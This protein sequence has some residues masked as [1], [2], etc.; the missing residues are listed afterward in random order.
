MVQRYYFFQNKSQMCGFLHMVFHKFVAKK[1]FFMRKRCFLFSLV[2]FITGVMG[3]AHAA[4]PSGGQTRQ[5]QLTDLVDP[6]IGTGGHG[7]VFL[8]AN[9]PFGLVQLGP[10]Q[11]VRGWDWCSGYHYSDSVLVGFSHMHLSGTGIGDLGDV[12][13]LPAANPSVRQT[14]HSHQQERVRPGYYS[15][16]MEREGIMA[17]LTATKRCGMHRYTYPEGSD[18]YLLINLDKGIGWDATTDC[19]LR[20]TDATTI[21]GCRR[22][23]GWA[24]DQWIFFAAEFS[25]PV[26]VTPLN[27]DSLTLVQAAAGVPLVVRVGLSPVSTDNALLNLREEIQTWDFD[28]VTAS[29][30][31]AWE[32]Q[33][34]KIRVT[35]SDQRA[36]RIFYT[37]LYHTMVA[38]SVYS[39]VNGDYRGADG[40]VRRDAFCNYTTF[41][42]W[43]TYRAAHPLMT[44]IHPEMQR[45]VAQTML[46]IYQQQG[47]LPV[48]H[49]MGN[50]T[51]CMVGNPAIPVVADLAIK[52]F[53]IDVTLAFEAARASAMREERGM[54][55]LQ[56]Y[57]FIPWDL[58]PEYETV[59]KGLE[60]ALAD[61]GVARLAK[62][63]GKTADEVAFRQR[64]R[65]YRHYFDPTTRFFR[66][67]DSLGHFRTP[68]SPFHA[69]HRKDD[70]T[71]GNAWQ[72]LWLVPHDVEGLVGLL[73]GPHKFAQKLDSLFVVEGDMGAE[74]SPDISGLIGQYA[75][76][77]EPSHHVIYLYNYV[78]MPWKA[79]PLLRRVLSELY[80]D[81]PDGLCGN[82]DVGQMSAWYV[83]SAMGLYQVE[84]AGGRYVIGSPLFDTM[85][86]NVGGGKT[87]KVVA[88]DN[89]KTNIYVQSARLNGRK[90]TRSY[91]DFK[92]IAAGG[93]LELV[94]GPRPSRFG[95]AKSDWP[96]S[97][98]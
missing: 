5:E 45:D 36:Q 23:H 80:S 66:G 39:D 15:L 87:F 72:Y 50:E 54:A 17:E 74:A 35:S 32:K 33:L 42:L 46:H 11:P 13:F 90:Y 62:M 86:M 30:S 1:D 52:G 44:L 7:H 10:T 79:A 98:F 34:S 95:R 91:V 78:G 14:L 28:A 85:E 25:K 21:V 94:M 4:A 26:T 3:M 53:D 58:D 49:L 75:H 69:S 65:S 37:A 9:V 16:R 93:T 83:L 61:D 60:Y 41:S 77:N 67:V 59:A 24:K 19:W 68:F 22:S 12:T 48:W 64:S 56:R 84:P 76:G 57:G 27:N 2:A 63:A 20:Q 89:S 29:A 47:K 40:K 31:E 6:Y 71:E 38:P 97:H 70:Y 18:Q 43:D 96:S 81:Q 55:L 73:G 82:E 8:G 51:D 92:D 88:R